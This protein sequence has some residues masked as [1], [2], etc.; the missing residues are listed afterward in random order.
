[1][2][3]LE[4]TLVSSIKLCRIY[5]I[6]AQSLR[7]RTK[8]LSFTPTLVLL[9]WEL[10]H[11]PLD[12]QIPVELIDNSFSITNGEINFHLHSAMLS[13]DLVYHASTHQLCSNRFELTF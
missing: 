1:M 10:I 12:S 7:A 9:N 2:R 6:L 8:C 13:Q 4:V 3:H 5:I 11:E